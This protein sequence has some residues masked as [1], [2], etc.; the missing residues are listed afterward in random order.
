MNTYGRIYQNS[1]TCKLLR[2]KTFFLTCRFPFFVKNLNYMYVFSTKVLGKKITNSIIKHMYGDIFLAGETTAE[3][4]KGLQEL[5]KEGLIGISDYA[6]EFLTKEEERTEIDSIIEM[7]KDSIDTSIRVDE[8]NSI[9]MKVSS[10]GDVEMMKRMNSLQYTLTL[11]ENEIRRGSNYEQIAEILKKHKISEKISENFIN[12]LKEMNLKEFGLNI[13]EIILSGNKKLLDDIICSLKIKQTD[14]NE[15]IDFVKTLNSRLLIVFDH[16]KSKNCLI[17][18]DAEQ[19]YLR[20]IT[21]VIAAYYFKKYNTGDKCIV[22]Q[23][24]QC[25]L[26]TQQEDLVKWKDFCRNN[27]IRFALKLVRGAYMSEESRIA[28]E[29]GT[30]SPICN[31][32]DETHDNYNK[33]IEYVFDNYQQGD[34]VRQIKKII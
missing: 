32:L 30:E 1:S 6:R 27:N 5:K 12:Q 9:A 13:F 22:A 11:L 18:I 8:K 23:T 34:K 24:L 10:F 20:F 16:A 21:D 33:S 17:M 3:L 19:S 7:Y 26:K 28:K 2:L 31:S 15:M 29:K 4:E 25:Y 14:L